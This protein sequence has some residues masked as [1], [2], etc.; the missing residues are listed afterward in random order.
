MCIE[1]YLCSVC[2]CVMCAQSVHA[3]FTH[4][5]TTTTHICI[6]IHIYNSANYVCD[7]LSGL[8]SIVEVEHKLF[9]STANNWISHIYILKRI[10]FVIQCL[11]LEINISTPCL[12]SNSS[13]NSKSRFDRLM[14]TVDY[15]SCQYMNFCVVFLLIFGI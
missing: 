15:I 14:S 9:D 11:N 4:T 7:I 6:F 12:C 5:H 13:E 8:V 3:S 10:S 1:V 2:D